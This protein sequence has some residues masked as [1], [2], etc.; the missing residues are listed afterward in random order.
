MFAN[1]FHR[2]KLQISNFSTS[3]TMCSLIFNKKLFCHFQ[4]LPAKFSLVHKANNNIVS[5]YVLSTCE[6]RNK[7]AIYF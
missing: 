4:G 3:F 2:S 6:I 7:L 1:F 5:K